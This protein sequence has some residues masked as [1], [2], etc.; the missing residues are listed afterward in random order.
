MAEPLESPFTIDKLLG[1]GDPRYTALEVSEKAGLD[2][3]Q[4]R[5]LWRA[6]GFVLI[7]DDEV[8]F[9]DADLAILQS[10]T[11]FMD[12]GYTD[13]DLVLGV[14][15]VMGLSVARI[16]ESEAEAIRNRLATS[17]ELL[18]HVIS[19]TEEQLNEEVI[20]PLE[21]FLV[22]VWKRQLVSA[23]QRAQVF[24]PQESEVTMAIGFVD[25]VGFTRLS[26]ELNENDLARLVEEFES[27]AQ[28][29]A[30]EIGTRIVKTIGDEVMFVADTPRA[31]AEMV[32][33]L[34]DA[35][36]DPDREPR[37]RAGVAYG[38]VAAHHGDYFG[39]TVNLASRAASVALPGTALVAESVGE[40][41]ADDETY[42]LK[43]VPRR[44]LKGIGSPQLY[45]LRRK[46][47]LLTEREER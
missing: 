4:T 5:R 45:V 19:R 15:R 25:I 28:D 17:P 46:T 26:R 43:P 35:Y 3:E 33:R 10:L 34:T 16:A 24:Q 30:T 18:D 36:S 20:Q 37:V 21:E 13:I 38:E 40:A 12:A 44:R 27:S 42:L 31:A 39:P 29:A 6:M 2:I 41:L 32:L 9:T 7:P 22:Y 8:F 14:T 1:L 47:P 11:R 23:L